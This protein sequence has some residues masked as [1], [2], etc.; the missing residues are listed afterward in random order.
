VTLDYDY[1]GHPEQDGVHQGQVAR[2]CTLLQ[3]LL[4]NEQTVGDGRFAETAFGLYTPP[5]IGPT[6]RIVDKVDEFADEG[7]G[8]HQTYE[9]IY[10]QTV[11]QV[12]GP[13]TQIAVR[14]ADF[15]RWVW[16]LELQTLY[17]T[18]LDQVWPADE[19]L[20]A[21]A[22]YALRT[23]AKAAFVMAAF[24][25]R[26][27]NSLSPKGLELALRAAGL[28][29]DQTWAS[30]TVQQLQRPTRVP[31]A[32]KVGRLRLYRYSSKDIFGYRDAGGRVLLYIPGNS[33]PLH[34]FSDAGQLHQWV[35]E[36]GRVAETKLALASH[37]A[38]DD[39]ED[40]A[41]HA[42]VLTALDGMVLYP[43]QHHLKRD[44][45]FFNN[46]GYWDP[47]EYIDFDDAPEAIDPFA[48]LVLT[49]KEAARVSVKT[50]RDDAQVNR[51]N[52][53]QVIEPAVQWIN[54]FAPLALFVP[55][56]EGLLALAG[57][58]D[59]GYGVD[60][61]INGKTP[62]DR[63]QGV[64]RTVFGLLNALPLAGAGSVLRGETADVGAI[65]EPVRDPA[66]EPQPGSSAPEPV[67][68][69]L[70]GETIRAPASRLELLRGIG[71]EVASFSDEVLLQIGKV[72]EVDDDMLRLMQTGRPM[73][74]LLADT[75]SRF[76][77]DHELALDAISSDVAP[78]RR[79]S[80]FN[81][82]YEALQ[83]TEDEWS[84]LFQKEYPGLPKN[85]I[86]QML[87]RYGVDIQ[88]APNLLEAKQ[89]L[90]RLDSKARQYQQ[91]VRFNRAY[92]GLYLSS[93]INSDSDTLVLHSLDQLPGW[94][95]G[96]RLSVHDSSVG[97][98]VLDRSGVPDGASVRR[99][100]KVGSRYL[101]RGVL[102][103]VYEAVL[104]VLFADERTALQLTSNDPAN[105]LRLKISHHAL[106]R[107]EFVRGLGRLDSGLP[108]DAQGL[109]GG[110]H[111]TTPQGAAL[112]HQMMR[113]Q[114]K[115]IYPEFT[116]AE[117]D[118]LLQRAGSGAQAHIEEL[119]RQLLQLNIDLNAWVE[120]VTQDINEMDIPFL[121]EN[122][123]EAQGLT[124]QQIA[125]RNVEILENAMKY[126]RETREELMEELFAIWQKR[127]PQENRVYSGERLVGYKID[128]G[129]EDYH[130]LPAMNI[131][132]SEVVE[133]SLKNFHVTER[134]TLNGFIECF[135]NLQTL[136][137]E[138]ADLSVFDDNGGVQGVLPSVIPDLAHLTSL[139]LGSTGLTF[140]EATASRLSGM[141]RLHT[142]DLSDNPLGV[143]PL[144]IG[145]NALRRLNL[146]NT[147]ITWCPIGIR[148]ET[149]MTLLDLRDNR[150]Q[151]IPQAVLNQAITRGRVLLRGNPLT[152]EDTLLR[153]VQHRQQTG[154]NVW[155]R[156]PGADYGEPVAW[157]RDVEEEQ[158]VAMQ[159]TWQRLAAKTNGTRFLRVIDG[160]SLTPDF[161]V[162][163]S[164]I[165]VRVW[166]V[167][168]EVDASDELWGWLSLHVEMADAES[169]DPFMMFTSIE[170]RARLYRDWV[171]MGRPIPI[172]SVLN[173]QQ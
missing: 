13:L 53:S 120:Q 68:A 22:P 164:Q 130:R 21:P 1:R 102:T 166:R 2:S 50:I 60:Q 71:T 127:A 159:A 23:S 76:R 87:D 20:A 9:G 40:G 36:Q 72:C 62:D 84:R 3:A 34:A 143:P 106:P 75:I 85:V 119:R 28:P 73:T 156:Q 129:Y 132:F 10:R 123:D 15:K 35:V 47:A 116:D 37:F 69:P 158:R 101:S 170:N 122:D 111:P 141:T 24:L 80:L 88:R 41:F 44:A 131:R 83:K 54:R 137:L 91:H 103:D 115:D 92:E 151:R 97:G 118:E 135:S 99:L 125:V 38:E 140:N 133:L 108:F 162:N 49:M 104:D 107:A 78:A 56:G 19:V 42:G 157:L 109:F 14:P 27:E 171:A 172:D 148:D 126:E 121:T 155:L 29:L 93:V 63:V 70:L 134:Q 136:N 154:I 32:L 150:I 124:E 152:D 5:D 4:S 153:L 33:S 77:I 86:E 43:R 128:L 11:P 112:T 45:G 6:I 52:L 61:V 82:R 95:K 89:V 30:L 17:Q 81:S 113:L 96:V 58:I 65:V 31:S 105:E 147:G 74:P 98:R 66:L 16:T 48:Q 100:I 39:R 165:Q 138:Y 7:S 145:M 79:V 160:L 168:S 94:P 161:L 18:Y 173:P 139:N 114:L 117:A 26:Q 57:L 55:G 144:L 46:D 25:Q 51:D 163:Y 169:D 90:T 67:I 59:A 167:L 64:T 8:N 142:L 149:Y 110:G 12:Y 146:R